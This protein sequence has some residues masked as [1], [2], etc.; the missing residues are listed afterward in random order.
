MTSHWVGGM[1]IMGHFRSKVARNC[2]C[3][4]NLER[5]TAD[6]ILVA[7]VTNKRRVQVAQENVKIISRFLFPPLLKLTDMESILL[8]IDSPLLLHLS[9]NK[10]SNQLSLQH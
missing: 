9:L 6:S 10:L 5:L 1:T 8:T 2:F 4:R 7:G 3:G